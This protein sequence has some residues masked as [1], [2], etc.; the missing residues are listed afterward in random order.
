MKKKSAACCSVQINNNEHKIK[1]LHN[2]IESRE[3]VTHIHIITHIYTN[4]KREWRKKQGGYNYNN[5]YN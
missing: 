4:S 2:E 3:K 1:K 5:L